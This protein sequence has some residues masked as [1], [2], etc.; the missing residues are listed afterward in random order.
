MRRWGF[1]LRAN[2]TDMNHLAELASV[3]C[4]FA[5]RWA[6]DRVDLNNYRHAC[7]DVQ[8]SQASS[9]SKTIIS[10][11]LESSPPPSSLL[12]PASLPSPLSALPTSSSLPRS[13]VATH[14]HLHT[15]LSRALGAHPTCSNRNVRKLHSS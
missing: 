11:H 3:S 14:R 10:V 6:A 13:Q 7:Q 12:S 9:W 1:V 8:T 5:S 15:F 4:Q 2:F